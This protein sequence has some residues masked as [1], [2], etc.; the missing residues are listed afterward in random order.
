[1]SSFCGNDYIGSLLGVGAKRGGQLLDQYIALPTEEA[2]NDFLENLE[3]TRYWSKSDQEQK[4]TAAGFA[5]KFQNSVQFLRHAPVFKFE[6]MEEGGNVDLS[7]PTSFKVHLAP[8]NPLPDS[9]DDAD[10][11]LYIGYN[12]HPTTFLDELPPKFLQPC[13][14]LMCDRERSWCHFCCLH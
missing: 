8:L 2:H 4:E 5:K 7:K 3:M 6:P 10:W 13:H 9:V 1:L 11:G 12:C 14:W